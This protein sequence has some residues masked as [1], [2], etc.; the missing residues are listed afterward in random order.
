MISVTKSQKTYTPFTEP[1]VM[2]VGIIGGTTIQFA[3]RIKT[4]AKLS[5]LSDKAKVSLRN[6]LSEQKHLCIYKISMISFN[7]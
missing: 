5:S 1:K 7:F 2:L 4:G 6:K 3:L